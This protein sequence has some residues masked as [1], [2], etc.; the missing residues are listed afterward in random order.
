MTE[1]EQRGREHV[2]AWK[3]SGLT[4]REYSEVHGFSRS[5]LGYWSWKING[6]KKSGN[7]VEVHSGRRTRG[8][9]SGAAVE[10][11]IGEDYRV[12]VAEGFSS[13]ALRQVLEILEKR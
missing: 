2:A 9:D 11:L 1:K 4:Q 8:L 6:E 10:L 3:A 13:E 7:F 12:R 5:A